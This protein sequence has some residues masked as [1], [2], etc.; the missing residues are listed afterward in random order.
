MT[1][2]SIKDL[3]IGFGDGERYRE[4]VS[5]V[6]LTIE[7]GE[8]LALVGESGSG[9]SL[10]ALSI[11]RLLAK[12]ARIP[13]GEIW[14]ND[15]D[16]LKSSWKHI[17]ELR[18]NRVGMIFQEPMTALNPLHPVER[19]LVESYKWH[20]GSK[21]ESAQQKIRELYEAIG[22]PHFIGR[23]NMYPHQLSGGERQRVMIG[24]AI[25]NNP[26]LLIADEPTTALDVTLQVQIL[27]LLKKLQHERNMGVLLITHDL[28]VV[29]KVADRVAVMKDGKIVETGKTKDVFENP[30]HAYT[31]ML[32]AA[33]PSGSAV[34][35]PRPAVDVLRTEGISVRY[36]IKS[37]VLRR[38]KGYV[39]AV[40]NLP[41][42][43]RSGETVGIVGESGSGKSSLGYGVLKMIPA[44]GEVVFLGNRI[45]DLSTKQI[46]PMR[47]HMQLVFQDPYASL[48][49]RMTVRDIIAEGLE[50]HEPQLR[51][52]EVERQ[53]D[54][55]LERVGL[56]GAMKARYPHEFSGGQRQRIAIARAMI[57]KPKLV[58]LDEPTSAL[59]M[60]VQGQVLD[61]LKDLQASHQVAYILISH[62]LRVI[63][64]MAH[65]IFVLKK[66]QVMEQGKTA[67]IFDNPQHEYTKS[68]MHAAF[69]E[70][71]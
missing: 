58:V 20:Q 64:A 59:D 71:L 18:G 48:N 55:I 65:Y 24:M 42:F 34:P 52:T 4:A 60:S 7:K 14:L 45:D 11:M 40:E 25:A 23:K 2:L 49:P 47:K 66:G 43:I 12:E 70:A 54:A 17:Q 29:R 28:T 8:L 21:G 5:G 3:H 69:G 15:E 37:A 67:E 26:D 36:P 19:Q 10:T 50:I 9:K 30:Q 27:K 35:I 44:E 6:S 53:V 62:D 31:K 46:R 16:M 61:L 41:L 63:K 22:L 39:N 13:K 51:R 38:T 56:T 32:L 57:L 68:L 1:L 33:M